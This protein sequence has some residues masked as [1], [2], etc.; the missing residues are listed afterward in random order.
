MASPKKSSVNLTEKVRELEAE[1]ARHDVEDR[2]LRNYLDFEMFLSDLS[3]DFVNISAEEVDEQIKIAL[4]KIARV[5]DADQSALLKI[6]DEKRRI[7]ILNARQKFNE[8]SPGQLP[9]VNQ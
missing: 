4:R 1:I 2:K 9:M 8:Y 3:T 5:C 6:E 7:H